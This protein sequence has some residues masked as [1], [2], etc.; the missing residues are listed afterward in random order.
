MPEDQPSGWTLIDIRAARHVRVIPCEGCS[1]L[2]V[3]TQKNRHAEV[4]P[5]QC[6]QDLRDTTQ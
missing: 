5:A 2:I 1:A 6:Q 4:C 3:E